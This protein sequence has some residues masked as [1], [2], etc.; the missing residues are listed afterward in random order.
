[1]K[2]ITCLQFSGG[3]NLVCTYKKLFSFSHYILILWMSALFSFM[4]LHIVLFYVLLHVFDSFVLWRRIDI[5]KQS[6]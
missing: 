3:Y 2:Q 1:M 5:I 4:K 6:K